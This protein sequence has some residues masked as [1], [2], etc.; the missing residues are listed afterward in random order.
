MPAIARVSSSPRGRAS[1]PSARPAI[2]TPPLPSS[3]WSAESSTPAPP[4]AAPGWH[5][6]P[7]LRTS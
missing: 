1:S 5:P 3:D 4:P 2:A 6:S 7:C